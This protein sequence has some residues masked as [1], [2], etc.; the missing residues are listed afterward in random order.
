MAN[1]ETT[2]AD[3]L[4]KAKL[5]QETTEVLAPP[6]APVDAENTPPEF[7]LQITACEDKNTAVENARGAYSTGA[8]ERR[9]LVKDYK[10]IAGRS[11]TNTESVKA[12]KGFAR[13]VRQVVRRISN[14]KLPKKDKPGDP[15]KKKRN[16]GTQ[17][18]ADLENLFKLLFDTL[19]GIPGYTHT[20][21]TL[22]LPAIQTANAAFKLKNEEM[23]S[24]EAAVNLRVKERFDL[25]NDKESGL[26][27]RMKEV[28][29]AV[30]N[31]YGAD[32]TQYQS[33]SGIKP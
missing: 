28:K 24:K 15:N 19:S 27:F 18:F 33:V 32:S 21:P 11:L 12:F 6:F 23:T 9:V 10:K 16:R 17:S 7:K 25:Y 5:L 8:T 22:Q 20:E 4:G 3:R 29:K 2:F 26:K 30:K 14:Y 13:T 31:Q 1:A